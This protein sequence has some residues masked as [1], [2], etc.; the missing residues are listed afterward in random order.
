MESGNGKSTLCG[1][2]LLGAIEQGCSVCA[3]SLEL[4][5][6]KFKEWIDLQAAGSE[7]ITLKE[8]PIKGKRVPVVHQPAAE[9]IHEWYDNKFFLYESVEDEQSTIADSILRVFTTAAKRKG[10]SIFLVDNLM[11]ALADS[12]DD[13]YRAQAR[14]VAQLKRF[15]VRYS[16]HVL[17]VAHP[18]KVKQGEP[19]TKS[20]VGGSSYITNLASNV[21]EIKKPDIN[22]LKSR[23]SGST[24]FIECCYC[25]DSRR[26][27]Q[28]SAGDLYQFSWNK[29]GITPP[30]V[31]ADELDEY[32]VRRSIM[33]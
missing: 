31:R 26:V 25:P 14:F 28:A 21:I 33:F 8:D 20:D 13:E 6:A 3:V 7:F 11:T 18:R 29:T 5:H 32:R 10:C 22:V 17:I 12:Y 9:R 4:P 15:A 30:A 1:T 27:Y 19:L 16:A 23:D 2:L 24:C